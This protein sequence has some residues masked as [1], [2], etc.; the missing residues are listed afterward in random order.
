MNRLWTSTWLYLGLLAVALAASPA[1]AQR[2]EWALAQRA[3]E[4]ADDSARFAQDLRGV[5]GYSGV[6]HYAR[7]VSQQARRLQDAI[8]RRRGPAQV[9]AHF[10]ALRRDM[11]QLENAYLR[12]RDHRNRALSQRYD[13]LN[14]VFISLQDT[15]WGQAL[16]LV[17]G[18]VDVAPPRVF[19]APPPM[20]PRYGPFDPQIPAFRGYDHRSA[21]LE[22]QRERL[23]SGWRRPSTDGIGFP[24]SSV[25]TRR[26]NHYEGNAGSYRLGLP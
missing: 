16:V 9:D 25:E 1:S 21:V 11:A 6:S 8:D 23:D 17:P 13:A 20:P 18:V 5:S 22:R 4:L 19:V 24:R 2:G 7:Q 15:R 26:P 14:T 10:N 3:A 12:T